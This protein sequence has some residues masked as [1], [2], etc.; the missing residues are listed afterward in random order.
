ME[1]IGLNVGERIVA[2]SLLPKAGNFAMLR[3]IN[4][5]TAKLGLSADEVEKYEL[6]SDEKTGMT[7]WNKLGIDE[8]IDIEFKTKEKEIIVKELEKL[9]KEEKLEQRH[10]SLYDKFVVEDDKDGETK[11]K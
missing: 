10:F 7:N 3:M 9:D 2:L 1:K 6:T 4:E 8:L 5:L 11:Q